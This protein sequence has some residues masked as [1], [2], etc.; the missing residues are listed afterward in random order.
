MGW[1]LVGT[2]GSFVS[3]SISVCLC[4][5]ALYIVGRGSKEDINRL[6]QI[7]FLRHFANNCSTASV[8]ISLTY[9]EPIKALLVRLF[10]VCELP[11][12]LVHC[13]NGID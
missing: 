8:Y 2:F 5:A 6:P 3:L 1:L 12:S 13:I 4:V 7:L 11:Y 9:K 10:A